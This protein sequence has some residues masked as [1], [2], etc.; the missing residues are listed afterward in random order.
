[1]PRREGDTLSPPVLIVDANQNK[2]RVYM[3]ANNYVINLISC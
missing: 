1:M 3:D 2:E